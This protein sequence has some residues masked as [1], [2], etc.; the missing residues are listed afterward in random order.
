[1]TRFHS[2]LAFAPVQIV[3][4]DRT[5]AR[6]IIAAEVFHGESQVDLFAGD[7]AKVDNKIVNRFNHKVFLKEFNLYNSIVRLSCREGHMKSGVQLIS[8]RLKATVALNRDFTAEMPI[9]EVLVTQTGDDYPHLQRRRETNHCIVKVVSAPPI[10]V[11]EKVK[12]PG[13]TEDT[14]KINHHEFQ[15]SSKVKPGRSTSV[16][17]KSPGSESTGKT[18]RFSI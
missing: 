11:H 6:T 14:S 7:F 9:Q 12:F 13:P 2:A 1:M 8:I 3:S 16:L 17:T 5:Q 18:K 10:P 15:I 4:T